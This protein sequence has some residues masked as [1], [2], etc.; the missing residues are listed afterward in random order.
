MGVVVAG[1]PAVIVDFLHFAT[2]E[3][4][5]YFIVYIKVFNSE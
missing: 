1:D 2:G 5:A 4:D 3:P